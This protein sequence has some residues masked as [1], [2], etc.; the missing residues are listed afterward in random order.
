MFLAGVVIDRDQ[1]ALGIDKVI[2][3]IA[4]FTAQLHRVKLILSVLVDI[5]DVAAAIEQYQRRYARV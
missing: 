5:G 4:R 2:L 3:C 1:R